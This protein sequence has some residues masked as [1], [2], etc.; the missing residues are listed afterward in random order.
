[1]EGRTISR[2]MIKNIDDLEYQD[3]LQI[4]AWFDDLLDEY[5]STNLYN[6]TFNDCAYREGIKDT[7]NGFHDYVVYDLLH[8]G[9]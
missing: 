1:M 6:Q 9:D 2:R 8:G 7:L 4:L 3:K 5:R